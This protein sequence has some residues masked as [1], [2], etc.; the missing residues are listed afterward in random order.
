MV[1]MVLIVLEIIIGVGAVGG[2]VY[3]LLGA[4]GVPR[5]WLQGSPFRSYAAPGLV[6]LVVVGGS[7]FAGAGLLLAD[8]SRA[9]SVSLIAGLVLVGWIVAQVSVVGRR[10]WLQPVCLVLGFA[11]V[12]LSL[13]LPSPG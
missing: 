12:V 3:V 11:V 5:E 7:M 9:R 13:F 2:G 4:P 1:R 10:H 8:A 6:L